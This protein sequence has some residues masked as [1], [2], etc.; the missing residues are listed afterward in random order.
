MGVANETKR[1][2]LKINGLDVGQEHDTRKIWLNFEFDISGDE[3]V[4]QFLI[5]DNCGLATLRISFEKLEKFRLFREEPRESFRFYFD[6]KQVVI[7]PGMRAEIPIWFKT[8]RP[9]TYSENWEIRTQPALWSDDFRVI[10]VLN[11][12]SCFKNLQQKIDTTVKLIEI[13]A[14][15]LL[16]K[17]L[18]D[19]CLKT[20][21]YKETPPKVCVYGEKE[22]FE[23]ANF[24][25]GRPQ[26]IYDEKLVKELN[27]IYDRVK[28]GEEKWDFSI[29]S[30]TKLAHRKDTIIYLDN[31]MLELVEHILKIEKGAQEPPKKIETKVKEKKQKKKKDK[32]SDKKTKSSKSST[33]QPVEETKPV[34]KPEP[35]EYSNQAQV[36]DVVRKFDS[37][38]I[39]NTQREK[40]L[41]CHS[42]LSAYFGKMCHSLNE[43]ELEIGLNST[44]TYP[45]V[46]NRLLPTNELPE[47]L[48]YEYFEHHYI[49]T[50]PLREVYPYDAKKKPKVL[51]HV[52][53]DDAEALYTIYFNKTIGEVDKKKKG[54]GG[55]EKKKGKEDKEK[56]KGKGDKEKKKKDKGDKHKGKDKGKKKKKVESRENIKKEISIESFNPYKEQFVYFSESEDEVVDNAGVKKRDLS[57][58]ELNDYKYKQYLIVYSSLGNAV[59]ALVDTLESFKYV[60]SYPTLSEV[61]SQDEKH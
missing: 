36:W 29:R 46:K 10:L 58:E 44:R 57:K 61:K 25:M 31:K 37:P 6:R 34:V 16:I 21:Q 54:K 38:V 1:L 20:I 33:S 11:A 26:F 41:T 4:S 24:S 13:K 50:V 48:V 30:L 49:P 35:F 60:V 3:A 51:R 47:R 53:S 9:G 2:D 55:K 18:L 59:D 52:P 42:I 15:N 27:Q 39:I 7:L 12:Y 22:L 5:F 56:K 40:Y 19:D 28:S 17:N 8:D 14:R 32:K 23:L 43:L 45:R